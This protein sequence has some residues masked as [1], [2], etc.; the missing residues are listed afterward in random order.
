MRCIYSEN[1]YIFFVLLAAA[2]TLFAAAYGLPQSLVIVGK[3]AVKIH[4]LYLPCEHTQEICP[5]F[6]SC[7]FVFLISLSGSK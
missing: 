4:Q 6:Q 7:C 3:N 1:T 5:L 2:H